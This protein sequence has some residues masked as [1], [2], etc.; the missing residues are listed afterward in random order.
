MKDLLERKGS[1]E[2]LNAISPMKHINASFPPAFIM[3]ANGDF[4]RE[5]AAPMAEALKELGVEV[6]YRCYGDESNKLPHVF[7]CNIKS[8]DARICN[9]DEAAF[10]KGK[11]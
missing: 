8:E 6:I 5:Q 7:H 10:F 1:K 3:T 2:E 4:L 11:L 9:D